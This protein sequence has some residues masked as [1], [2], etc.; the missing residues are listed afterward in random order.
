MNEDQNVECTLFPTAFDTTKSILL[1]LSDYIEGVKSNKYEPR[2]ANLRI[3]ID[4]G[5]AEKYAQAKKQLPLLVA[6]GAME[7]GRKIQFMVRY[8]QCISVDVD[9]VAGSA[10]QML[11]RAAAL[12]YM[13]AGYVSPSGHGLKL[14]VLVDTDQAHHYEAFE[15]VRALTEKD[16]PG[17]TVDISG[18]D[19]NRGCFVSYDPNAFYKD[20]SEVIHVPIPLAASFRQPIPAPK[21]APDPAQSLCNYVDKFEQGNVFAPGGRHS[22]VLKLASALNSAGFDLRDVTWECVT[23]YAGGNFGEK[24][25]CAIVDDVYRRYS[26]S[27]G[28]KIWCPPAAPMPGVSL[29][30]L[31]SINPIP[32]DAT[33]DADDTLG[34][35]IEPDEHHFTHFDKARFKHLPTLLADVLKMAGSDTEYDLMLLAAITQLA[36]VTPGVKGTLMGNPYYAPFYTILVG[37][38]GSGKG[39]INILRKLTEKWQ[40][41]VAGNSRSHVDEYLEKKE[42]YELF[43]LQQRQGRNKQVGQAP[44]NPT[45]VREMQLGISGYTTTA[46]LIELLDINAPYASL[47]YET[48]L[49]SVNNTMAQDFGGYGYVLNQAFQHEKVSSSSKTTGTFAAA[50]PQLGALLSGTPGMLNVL[51]PSTENGLFSRLLIYNIAGKS[52]YRSLTSADNTENTSNYFDELGERVLEAGVFLQ[53]WPTFVC[54]SDKQRKKLD[55]YFEREYYNV[56]VFGNED[57]SSVVLRHRLIIFRIAMVLT[58]LRKAENKWEFSHNIISDNDFDIAFHIGTTCL[59]HSLLISTTMKHSDGER[60]YKWPDAQ[61]DLFAAMP[62]EFKTADLLEEAAVRGL[63]R[64]NV[65]RMLRKAQEYGLVVLLSRGYYRKTDSGKNVASPEIG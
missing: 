25:I 43:K 58:A 40:N 50:H 44:E 54:F 55:R 49:E 19:P 14:F 29:N 41:W 8:S 45:P 23:R 7:G 18:K 17:L 22:Y 9:H 59:R 61:R 12:P 36:T 33:L 15:H 47:L 57:V 62:D 28:S 1:T 4:S 5:E 27:H 34:P 30:S 6:G 64:A 16:L 38:S 56:R 26:T 46:R 35:D 10:D 11:V 13:K 20:N 63:S 52:H 21:A 53:K 32:G 3:L 2:I 48:E 24:E 60:H 37:P 31:K 39:C 65:F 42:A 51:V